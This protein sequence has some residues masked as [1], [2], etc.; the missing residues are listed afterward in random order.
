MKANPRVVSQDTFWWNGAMELLPGLGILIVGS[1][2]A[3]G[4][5][6]Y[7]ARWNPF[8]RLPVFVGNPEDYP[9]GPYAGRA[10]GFMFLMMG[11]AVLY[12]PINIWGV[13][14]M[15]LAAIPAL[16]LSRDHNRRLDGD[17]G[18]EVA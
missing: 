14:L 1:M 6:L 5:T 10:M 3:I 16:M 8:M 15:V 7:L 17:F 11:G 12:M 9:F 2:M 4:T 13:F 18:P